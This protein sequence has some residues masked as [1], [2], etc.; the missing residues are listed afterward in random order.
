MEHAP[1]MEHAQASATTLYSD[2]NLCVR[3]LNEWAKRWEAQE[4]NGSG[5]TVGPPERGRLT[6][7]PSPPTLTTPLAYTALAPADLQRIVAL[8]CLAL[9]YLLP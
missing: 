9:P 6:T 4:R 1:I 2:S 3:T 5:S 7:Q 8:P